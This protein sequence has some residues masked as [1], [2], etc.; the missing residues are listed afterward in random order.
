MRY[1]FLLLVVVLA[2]LVTTSADLNIDEITSW[3]LGV[4]FTVAIFSINFT[5]FGYQL[6]KYKAIYSAITKRQWLNIIVLLSLPLLPLISFLVAPEYFEKIALW[7]LPILIFSSI[8]N[9]I[10]TTRYLSADKFIENSINDK[11]IRKYID[12]LSKE[13]KLESDEHQRHL[14]SLNEN[15]MPMHTYRFESS[16]LGIEPTDLWDSMTIVT[17]LSVD[18]NDY[19]IFRKS[20]NAILRIVVSFYSFKSAEKDSHKIESGIQNIARKRFRSIIASVAEKDNNGIFLQALS[21]ELCNFLMEDDLFKNPCSDLSRSITSDATWIAKKILESHNVIEPI[22][23]LNTI[24]RIAEI[25]IYEM[26]RTRPENISDEINKYYISAYAYDI[27]I[28]GDAA[29]NNGNFHFAY[30]CMESLSY[31][32]CSAAK[33]K[34]K[35]TVVAAFESIVQM[36]R[37]AR[38]LKI[39]CFWSRCLIPA[40]SHAEEFMGHILT[41]LIQ[42]IDTAGNF[43]M[44]AHAEQAYSRIR[45]FKCSIKP[46]ANLNPYFW[47]NEL[48]ENGEKIPH[49]EHES[50]RYG[51]NGI[52]DYSDFSNL[53]DYVLYGISPGSDSIIAHG[54]PMPL[55]IDPES[56]RTN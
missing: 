6:S 25:N 12:A 21:N 46:K 42:D 22:K 9:A 40:E 2:I 29:L 56:D 53:K 34:S 45:G 51:Y 18:N 36:G 15:P 14:D 23:A 24:H 4:N 19:P 33:L 26:E 41:W 43:F 16:T 55:N 50:G 17:N 32:G 52:S 28:L 47:I 27:K 37:L 10:L 11:T 54:E 48:K 7:I 31:L 5:F 39:G 20:L 1:I 44:K 3:L 38:K 13:I 30:R 35:Q 49:I 8:D